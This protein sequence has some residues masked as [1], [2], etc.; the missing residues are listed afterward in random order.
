MNPAHFSST[1]KHPRMKLSPSHQGIRSDDRDC[2]RMAAIASEGLSE[3]VHRWNLRDLRN[4]T[5]VLV[6]GVCPASLFQDP[7][8]YSSHDAVPGSKVLPDSIGLNNTTGVILRN[9]SASPGLRKVSARRPGGVPVSV[10]LDLGSPDL[11]PRPHTVTWSRGKE[12]GVTVELPGSVSS[13]VLTV[14]VMEGGAEMDSYEKV[15]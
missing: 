8:T 15:R 11:L 2:W 7:S 3:G 1:V 14:A 10:T 9:G 5:G 4:K 12:Q 13:W 6:V